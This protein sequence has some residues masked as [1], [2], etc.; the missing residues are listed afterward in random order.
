MSTFTPTS[1]RASKLSCNCVACTTI[2]TRSLLSASA[3]PV[4]FAARSVAPVSEP[5]HGG[6]ARRSRGA[7]D[8]LVGHCATDWPR[9]P[10]EMAVRP[11]CRTF[12]SQ[13]WD[14]VTTVSTA[15]PGRGCERR[16]RNEGRL[17]RSRSST[18]ETDAAL[19]RFAPDAERIDVSADTFDY[20]RLLA[21]LGVVGEDFAV[22]EHDVEPHARV[23]P[24]FEECPSSW[25][26]FQYRY[27][28]GLEIV[29]F[30]CAGFAV[31][32]C[33]TCPM[34][35]TILAAGGGSAPGPCADSSAP[36][37]SLASTA[38]LSRTI[39]ARSVSVTRSRYDDP[40]RVPRRP[41]TSC[42][43]ERGRM[44]WG[45]QRHVSGQG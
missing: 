41:R 9:S 8:A 35:S 31:R 22:I 21:D 13:P 44:S 38:T 32:S 14:I 16:W 28:I 18:T 36:V 30:G 33:G 4:S 26:L 19:S 5:S 7:T 37:T 6:L 15:L 43:D 2:T 1:S 45:D 12:T 24:T 20:W 42:V 27:P 39:V 11:R 10:V 17:S 34:H 23:F 29:G 3:G 40:R 25:C